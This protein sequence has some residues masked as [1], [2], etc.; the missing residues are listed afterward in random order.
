MTDPLADAEPDAPLSVDEL[1]TAQRRLVYEVSGHPAVPAVLFADHPPGV[2]VGR[3]GSRLQVRL[4][5]AQLVARKLPLAFVPRGGGAMLHLP[6]QATCYPIL[7][8]SEFGVSPGEY[9]RALVN[10][11]AAVVA[12][13][14]LPVEADEQAVTVRVRGRRIA[15]VG[16]AVRNGVSLFGLVINVSPDL[17]PFRDID[18]DGD[19]TPMTSLQ[20]ESIARVTL[21][22]VRQRLMTAVCDRFALRRGI[23]PTRRPLSTLYTTRYAFTRRTG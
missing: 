13:Y 6:G 12:K 2:T 1:T 9:A 23:V 10:I 18:V 16:A 21:A 3:E 17:E 11:A 20:R 4:T 7:P 8:L 5:D 15:H 22:A 14:D 19:P